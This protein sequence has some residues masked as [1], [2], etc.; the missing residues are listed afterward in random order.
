ML[1]LIDWCAAT[2]G[3]RSRPR[4]TSNYFQLFA[5]NPVKTLAIRA[6]CANIT[7]GFGK[8]LPASTAGTEPATTEDY[9]NE[10]NSQPERN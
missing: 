2:E 5:S 10:R 4:S 3:P 1:A 7:H 9:E 8:S 6:G